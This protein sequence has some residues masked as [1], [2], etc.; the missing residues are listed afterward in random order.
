MRGRGGSCVFLK[1]SVMGGVGRWQL[2]EVR[3]SRLNVPCFHNGQCLLVCLFSCLTI[4]E[5][6]SLN[7]NLNICILCIAHLFLSMDFCSFIERCVIRKNWEKYKETIALR[8]HYHSAFLLRVLRNDQISWA[9][10]SIQRKGKILSLGVTSSACNKS[11]EEYRNIEFKFLQS[12]IYPR[13]K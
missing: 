3:L 8:R 5:L 7:L 6:T 12:K 2:F 10:M 11:I 4:C 1:W 13:W 9:T